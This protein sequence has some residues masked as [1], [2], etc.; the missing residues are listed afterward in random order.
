[1]LRFH[2]TPN[3]QL[4]A[5][6]TQHPARNSLAFLLEKADATGNLAFPSGFGR[7]ERHVSKGRT[8]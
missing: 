4:P 5:P 1:M 7:M 3:T 8:A 6:G 2:P